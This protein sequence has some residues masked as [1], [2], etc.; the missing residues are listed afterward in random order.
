MTNYLMRKPWARLP[1]LRT[2]GRVEAEGTEKS[3]L[4]AIWLWLHS[5]HRRACLNTTWPE[6][7]AIQ[8]AAC[9]NHCTVC[10]KAMTMIRATPWSAMKGNAPLWM[11]ITFTSSG[12]TDCR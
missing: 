11:S 1:E 2:R 8:E 9:T 5:K 10:G 6:S 12:A 7:I 3:Q 4:N